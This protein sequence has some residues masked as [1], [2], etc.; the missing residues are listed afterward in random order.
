MGV[1]CSSISKGC[2]CCASDG[3]DKGTAEKIDSSCGCNLKSCV[4]CKPK[5]LRA[6]F[7]IASDGKLYEAKIKEIRHPSSSSTVNLQVLANNQNDPNAQP[8]YVQCLDQ[9]HLNMPQFS[10]PQVDYNM[11]KGVLSKP[12]QYVQIGGPVPSRLSSN[13]TLST[14]PQTVISTN[15]YASTSGNPSGYQHSALSPQIAMSDGYF[16]PQPLVHYRTSATSGAT[17]APL[18]KTITDY[19]ARHQGSLISHPAA[20]LQQP[21]APLSPLQAPYHHDDLDHSVIVQGV[22][23]E[24]SPGRPEASPIRMRG[25]S[26]GPVSQAQRLS[27]SYSHHSIGQSMPGIPNAAPMLS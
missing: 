7:P 21:G 20:P 1:A 11:K 12:P 13:T 24:D 26:F 10:C 5:W 16:S 23:V 3:T 9:P 6:P 14:A 19:S 17:V 15:T 27:A 22:P 2:K 8:V 18:I 25:D 4:A